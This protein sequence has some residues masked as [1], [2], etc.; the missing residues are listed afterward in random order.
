V[1]NLRGGKELPANLV[2]IGRRHR[3]G[4]RL[5]PASPLGNPFGKRHGDRQ[6]RC[7]LYR[8]W[9]AGQVEAGNEAVL[10]ALAAIK[11]ESVLGCWCKPD[12]CHGDVIVEAWQALRTGTLPAR[13]K[14]R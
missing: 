13:A 4:K 5:W 14:P 8:T 1:I 10:A 12:A 7:R 2:Y 3:Q 9:L 11:P 6:E